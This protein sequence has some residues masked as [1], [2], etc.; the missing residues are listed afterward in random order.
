M[1]ATRAHRRRTKRHSSLQR[2]CTRRRCS[3]WQRRSGSQRRGGG[4]T[5][6][7]RSMSCWPA[8]K[9]SGSIGRCPKPIADPSSPCNAARS[10]LSGLRG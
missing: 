7:Q 9:P 4:S 10:A 5:R 6:R 2:R 3:P 8:V 1:S